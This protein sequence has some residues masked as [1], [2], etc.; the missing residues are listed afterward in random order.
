MGS[1]ADELRKRDREA[2]R[3]LSVDERI[4]LALKLGEEDLALFC[5]HQGVDRRTGIR[6][7]QR[8]RQ[9]GRRPSKCMSDL[10]G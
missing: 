5:Q 3:Q 6:L 2:I 1:V 9:A 7:L 10:I 4:E 8:R